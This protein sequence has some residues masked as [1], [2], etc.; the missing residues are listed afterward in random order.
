MLK[1]TFC[2]MP[3]IGPKTEQRL[4]DAG[5][6]SWQAACEGSSIVLPAHRAESVTRYAR[7]SIRR[8]ASN[9]P[10]YFYDRLP[11]NQHW[12]LFPE[13]RHSV[14]YLDI[15]TTGLGPP[16]DYITTIALYDGKSI[17]HYVRDDNLE[18]FTEDIEDYALIVT[19]SGKTFD[20]PFIRYYFGIPMNHA[21]IDL[22]YVLASL[23]YKGGLKGCEKSL[24]LDRGEL[25]GIDGYFAVLLWHDY[26]NNDNR[27]A[28]DTL[29]AYN[30]EDVVNL[31]TLMVLAY[32]M[33]VQGTVFGK[34]H[35]LPAPA[36][37]EIPFKPDMRTVERIRRQHNWEIGTGNRP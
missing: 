34:S 3:G 23:G 7:E 8:L 15:E 9:D 21:H 28:L 16:A 32:N 10:R 27:G 26:L 5:I 19:Y 36:I 29:L 33:K 17:R 11:T 2:H 30:I 4:W 24:G 6:H 35:N 22:R 14:A 20:V 1:N 25:D 12:R 13:F 18:Q 37:P 31:E